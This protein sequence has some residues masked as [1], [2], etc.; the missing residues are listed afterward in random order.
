M[1]SKPESGP[2]AQNAKNR[3]F[4][5]VHTFKEGGQTFKEGVHFLGHLSSST[6]HVALVHH[7]LL[8]LIRF[9]F[10]C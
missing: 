6:V 5:H 7:I 1:C 9:S 4:L 2:G 10:V 8:L 3:K